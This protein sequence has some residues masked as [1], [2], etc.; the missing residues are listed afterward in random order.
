MDYVW[1]QFV[2]LFAA[3]QASRIFRDEHQQRQALS[4]TDITSAMKRMVI[5][6]D[7]DIDDEQFHSDIV[8]WLHVNQE[9]YLRPTPKAAA[10]CT[11]LWHNGLYIESVDLYGAIWNTV[12]AHHHDQHRI[13]WPADSALEGFRYVAHP[14]WNNANHEQ[15][16]TLFRE[17]HVNPQID[18]SLNHL[19]G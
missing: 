9:P 19:L 6:D 4:W 8:S 3:D 13:G 17:R 16:C 11:W 18:R 14:Y 12:R 5:A 15:F 7:S 2:R 10:L 1:N